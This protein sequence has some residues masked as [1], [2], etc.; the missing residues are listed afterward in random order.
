M[1][2]YIENPHIFNGF[3]YDLRIYI[4]I[5]SVDPLRIYIYKNG[6][7][8][9]CTQKYNTRTKNCKKKY[10]HLT[11]FAVNKKNSKFVYNELAEVNII[12]RMTERVV[13][14]H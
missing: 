7:V 1:S 6:I 13:N 3:K 5:T 2:R 4:L 8:R 10:M 14:G 12:I 11:N 9:F